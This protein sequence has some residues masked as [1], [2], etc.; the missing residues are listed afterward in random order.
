MKKL[1]HILFLSCRKAT[2]LI[3]KKLY[4]KLNFR[5]KIQLAMHKTMC[6][7]C[8]RYEKQGL[9]I[10]HGIMTQTKDRTFTINTEE[11]KKNIEKKLEETKN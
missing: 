4:F 3:D 8:R 6:N 7:A 11:L 1:M 9:L 5:E 2:E 10:E